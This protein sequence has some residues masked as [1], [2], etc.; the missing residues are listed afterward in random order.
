MSKKTVTILASIFAVF[1]LT[2]Q[3]CSFG[4]VGTGLAADC[5]GS[6]DIVCD[7]T[8]AYECELA[9]YGVGYTVSRARSYDSTNC[10]SLTADCGASTALG[11]TEEEISFDGSASTGVSTYSWDF[12]GDGTEDSTDAATTY[13]YDTEGRYT[14]TLIVTDEDENTESCDITVTV[15]EPRDTD[16]DGMPDSWEETYGLDTET[17]DSEDD[18]DGDELSNLEEYEAGTDPTTTDTD[19][20]GYDDLFELYTALS[21]PADIGSVPA[22][23]CDGLDNDDDGRIDYAICSSPDTEDRGCSS[24]TDESEE[25]GTS[26]PTAECSASA[27]DVETLESIDFDGSGSTDDGTITDYSWDFDTD[28]TEDSTDAATAYSY[29]TE[30]TY[31]VTLTVTDDDGNTDDCTIDITVVAAAETLAADCGGTYTGTAHQEVSFDGSASTGDIAEYGWDFGDNDTEGPTSIVSDVSEIVTTHTYATAGT[32]TLTLLVEESGATT[33]DYCTTTVTIAGCTDS[34]SGY[35]YTTKGTVTGE[36]T[37]L[38][39]SDGDY[40]WTDY[41]KSDGVGIREFICVSG[42]GQVYHKN[43]LTLGYTSCSDG[44]CI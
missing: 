14:A 24:E 42:Y 4:A 41:C 33:Q 20:D 9:S 43:C 35:D 18:A 44:A 16:S 36:S 37:L 3:S 21:D 26:G 5:V 6:G 10:G 32:Y 17:D 28:G 12:D 2:A 30:G 25:A 19:G 11:A 22:D 8:S 31:T 38:G 34:D 15:R 39:N 40:S 27:T 23:C 1:F 13:S 7:G 29:D